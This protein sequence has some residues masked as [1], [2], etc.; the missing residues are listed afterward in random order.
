MQRVLI[1]LGVLVPLLVFEFWNVTKAKRRGSIFLKCA[2]LFI[3]V[4]PCPSVVE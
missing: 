2:G 1:E 4:H 3:R